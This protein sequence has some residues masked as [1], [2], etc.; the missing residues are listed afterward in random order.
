[1]AVKELTVNNFAQEV[2][3]S[4][5]IV[6][7]DFWAA[8][9]GP[10]QMLS[11]VVD[12]LSEQVQGVKVMKCNTDE[13]MALAMQFEIDAI[14]ALLKFKDGKLYDKMVGFAPAQKVKAFML[15]E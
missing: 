4:K 1:M 13:Q 11:P 5:G 3:N 14:P 2:A 8:W 12:A 9:C 6:V 10:C 7:V 15:A